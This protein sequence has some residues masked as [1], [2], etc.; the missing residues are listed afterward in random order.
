MLVRDRLSGRLY[1]VPE[2]LASM[3]D[4][5]QYALGEVHDAYGN[6]LGAFLLPKI[7]QAFRGA[8]RPR[9]RHVVAPAA[10]AAPCPPCPP[11]PPPF[12]PWMRPPFGPYP[13]GP[14]GPGGGMGARRRRRRRRRRD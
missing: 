3:P 4:P 7:I 12:P 13:F 2:R 1:E 5:R 6:S 10:A 8:V 14:F 9:V 11:C